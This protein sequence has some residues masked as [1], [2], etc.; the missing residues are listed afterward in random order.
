MAKNKKDPFYS[1]FSALIVLATLIY[2]CAAMQT[3]QGGPKDTTPPK[4]LKMTPENLTTNFTA[5]KSSSNL[6]SML[7]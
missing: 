3:P 6:M 2:G 4:V 5:K 7:N 1:I